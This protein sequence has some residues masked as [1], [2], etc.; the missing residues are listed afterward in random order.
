MHLCLI[1]GQRAC[2]GYVTGLHEPG[3]VIVL[4]VTNRLPAFL[5]QSSQFNG[6]LRTFIFKIS[7]CARPSGR[8][9]V[10]GRSPVEIVGSNP[11][12]GMDGSCECCVL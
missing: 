3:V 12:A 1:V 11:A 8:A 5:H 4:L 7:S 9:S 2:Y 6:S 10:C